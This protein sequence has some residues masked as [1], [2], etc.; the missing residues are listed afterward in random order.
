MRFTNTIS[1]IIAFLIYSPSVFAAVESMNKIIEVNLK[2]ERALH[3]QLLKAIKD[4][5]VAQTYDQYWNK[6]QASEK[7]SGRNISVRLVQSDL[8]PQKGFSASN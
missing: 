3:T 1:I 6:V 4:T 7:T 2:E 5:P 8:E